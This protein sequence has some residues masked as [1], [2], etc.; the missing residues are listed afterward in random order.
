MKS[1]IERV[2]NAIKKAEKKISN[3]PQ[4]VLNMEGMSSKKVRMF[5]NELMEADTRYLEIGVWKGSTFISAMYGKKPEAAFAI[6]NWSQFGGNATVFSNNCVAHDVLDFITFHR[7][8][9]NLSDEEKK[10][11]KNINL[12]FYDGGH[13]AHDTKAALTYY[14]PMLADEFILIID[15]WNW[16]PVKLGARAGIEETGIKIKKEWE[17][18]ADRNGDTAKWWN[19]VYVAVCEKGKPVK[20]A[21]APKSKKVKEEE[22]Q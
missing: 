12:Y 6:D 17:L 10:Q 22:S 19:G 15:D 21:A 18:P 5:L 4:D 2:N 7:D 14:L 13:K 1:Y 9:F 3:L 8:C 11:I 20:K 16:E